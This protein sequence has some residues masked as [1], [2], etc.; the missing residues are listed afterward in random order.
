MLKGLHDVNIRNQN[1]IATCRVH[2]V[3]LLDSADKTVLGHHF[4]N[5]LEDGESAGLALLV[6]GPRDTDPT[7]VSCENEGGTD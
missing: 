6:S 3:L 4:L 5:L 7:R 1:R 2:D